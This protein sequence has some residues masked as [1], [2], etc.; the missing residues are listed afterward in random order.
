MAVLPKS[1]FGYELPNAF[2]KV[3]RIEKTTYCKV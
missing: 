3:A 2:A 1:V